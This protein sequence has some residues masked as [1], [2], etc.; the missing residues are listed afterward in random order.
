MNMA[1]EKL[2]ISLNVVLKKKQLVGRLRFRSRFFINDLRRSIISNS[3]KIEFEPGA[4]R[5]SRFF[6]KHKM[7]SLLSLLQSRVLEFHE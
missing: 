6:G 2:E 3:N 4:K 1:Q 5:F 7:V